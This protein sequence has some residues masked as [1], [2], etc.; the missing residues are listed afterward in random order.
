MLSRMKHGSIIPT[1]QGVQNW[2]MKIKVPWEE[3]FFILHRG[4]KKIDLV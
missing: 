3:S 4:Q 1:A 2:I